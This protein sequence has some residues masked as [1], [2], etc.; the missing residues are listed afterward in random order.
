MASPWRTPYMNL[1]RLRCPAAPTPS[2]SAIESR[3]T[4]YAERCM[5][6]RDKKK[7]KANLRKSEADITQQMGISFYCIHKIYG[8]VANRRGPKS[9]PYWDFQIYLFGKGL[10][11]AMYTW[12]EVQKYFS[13]SP[14]TG[15]RVIET[16]VPLPI[17]GA[18][19]RLPIVVQPFLT[20]TE[21]TG[22][23][24][25]I[26]GIRRAYARGKQIYDL[27][28]RKKIEWA[29]ELSKL[30]VR[31]VKNPYSNRKTF[32]VTSSKSALNSQI[33]TYRS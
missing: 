22:T 32:E 19:Y 13:D 3:A 30:T 9:N 15:Y 1:R 26:S 12:V 14:F 28:E 23:R 6:D 5:N 21:N 2:R 20:T 4:W 29:D 31:V 25:S 27:I 24:L 7:F 17:W 16:Y 10:R 11:S 18:N 33:K 8:D